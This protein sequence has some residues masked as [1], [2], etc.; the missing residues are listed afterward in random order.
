MF[1]DCLD[2]VTSCPCPGVPGALGRLPHLMVGCAHL[3]YSSNSCCSSRIL[4]FQIPGILSIAGFASVAARHCGTT[5]G[6]LD[7]RFPSSAAGR[8]CPLGGS[9][10]LQKSILSSGFEFD[11]ALVFRYGDVGKVC[12]FALR[13][14]GAR[15]HSFLRPVQTASS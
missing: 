9:S 12:A 15:N 1:D 11:F 4:V 3:E 6:M 13:D 7:L 14:S 8:C 2:I 10:E 5:T